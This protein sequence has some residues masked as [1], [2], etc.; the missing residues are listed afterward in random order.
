[1]SKR[2]AADILDNLPECEE[3]EYGQCA[4]CGGGDVCRD[5]AESTLAD[6]LDAVQASTALSDALAVYIDIWETWDGSV[7]QIADGFLRRLSQ[8]MMVNKE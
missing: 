7:G 5:C 3:D 1:M 2:T 4:V 6:A 8:A